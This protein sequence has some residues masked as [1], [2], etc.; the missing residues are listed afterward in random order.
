MKRSNQ[1]VIFFIACLF[2]SNTAFSA[3]IPER[4][5]CVF[6]PIGTR[7]P[8]Y[9]NMLDYQ[10]AALGWGV[11]LK[12]KAYTN[13][14]VVLADFKSGLCDAMGVTGTRVPPY[15]KFTGSIEAIGAVHSYANLRK[16]IGLISSPKAAKF[17]QHKDYEVAGVL[18]GGAVYVFVRDKNINSVEAAAGKRVATIEYDK[19]SRMVVKKIGATMVPASVAT[20]ATRFNNG[21]VDIAYA[22]AIAYTPFEMHKGLGENGGIYPFVLAQMNF[23]MLLHKARFPQ[24]F[25][26]KSRTYAF[27]NF[28]EAMKHIK[29]A[30]QQIPKKYW[31]KLPEKKSK[32][33]QEMFRQ[34]RI[35][36]TA[37]GAY[38]KRM[39]KIMFKLRCR[40]NP[41]HYE[42]VEKA[43]G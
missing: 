23:Q 28:D 27:S 4:I 32:A 29:L 6:D 18:P 9:E 42:C 30:E 43:E 31:L 40:D 16:L 20:F 7:G 19:A 21:D 1:L 3:N 5:F 37:Q 10:A 17:M 15:N 38:D 39:I 34:I 2:M 22:P 12:L 33:Y 8:I 24:N 26:Q 11:K 35:E 13:E 14:A 36:L 25:A 41:K